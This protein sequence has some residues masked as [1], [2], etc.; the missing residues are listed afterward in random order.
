MG[1]TLVVHGG[2]VGGRRLEVGIGSQTTGGLNEVK[3]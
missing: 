3:E 1:W 2:V